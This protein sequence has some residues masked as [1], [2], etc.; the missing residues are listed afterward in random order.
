[1]SERVTI[2]TLEDA[3]QLRADWYSH[4]C[5]FVDADG[6]RVDPSAVVVTDVGE[7]EIRPMS[8]EGI[9]TRP[10]YRPAPLNT[11]DEPCP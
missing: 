5:A 7:F 9:A 2:A 11:L 8:G 10:V 6:K 1:M 4:G 3:V